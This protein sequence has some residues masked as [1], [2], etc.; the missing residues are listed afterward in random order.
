MRTL[1]ILTIFLIAYGSLFPFDFQ[2]TSLHI[3]IHDLILLESGRDFTG[4]GDLLANIALFIPYG[5][6]GFLLANRSHQKHHKIFAVIALGLLSSYTLQV[7]QLYLPSRYAAWNDIF[8][9][10]MGIIVG[11]L[12]ASLPWNKSL[13]INHT[14]FAAWRSPQGV[15]VIAWLASELIPFVPTLAVNLVWGNVKA[16]LINTEI[17]PLAILTKAI[18]W[19]TFAYL[20]ESLTGKNKADSAF[21]LILF[22]TLTAKF[23]IINS[24][25][26][27][28][29]LLGGI[30]ALT[31]WF[32]LFRILKYGKTEKLCLLLLASITANGILPFGLD[33]G[34]QVFN[35][36]P[37]HGFLTGDML[38]NS[39][40]LCEKLFLYGS[41]IWLLSI[42]S[43]KIFLATILAVFWVTLIEFAQI[44]LESHTPEITDPILI[45]I[46]AWIF[47]QMEKQHNAP[48]ITPIVKPTTTQ[49]DAISYKYQARPWKMFS[50]G[51]ITTTFM[52]ALAMQAVLALPK[53]PYNIKEL[54]LY[55]GNIIATFIFSLALIWVGLSSRLCAW[56]IE[57]SKIQILALPFYI[58]LAGIISLLILKLSVTPES[59][60][61]IAGSSNLN[62]QV[63]E[64]R[65]WGDIGVALFNS[66]Q[67]PQLI[68]GIERTVRYLA[69]YC[70]IIFFLVI[71]N[72]LLDHPPG[73]PH[74]RGRKWILLFMS[75]LPWL[76]L[77]KVIAFDYSSTDNLNELIARPGEYGIGGGGY[78]YL[79]LILITLNAVWLSRI[80]KVCKLMLP[81]LVT[82]AFIPIGWYLFSNGLVKDF[83]KYN[84]IYSGVDFLLGPSRSTL[85]PTGQLF[86]RWSLVQIA[87]VLL[88][89]FSQK[90]GAMIVPHHNQPCRPDSNTAH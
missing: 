42:P 57:K 38:H 25:I 90:L 87:L 6:I 61:D 3:T 72:I 75:A 39:Q 11:M 81:L 17:A 28:S 77:C 48:P 70:P 32:S 40:I 8:A 71:F 83:Q 26:T 20:L 41:L 54:F 44:F 88:L 84:Q 60:S 85:L 51:I 86:L 46:I 49:Q 23:F 67:A 9:N 78:L 36:L 16:L 33:S 64:K 55:N 50:I 59:I 29:D 10:F 4:L 68:S 76:F 58:F 45:V 56:L 18:S 27:T 5:F 7:L 34:A 12:A 1:F 15:L 37:F 13:Y 82:A 30:L 35:W 63:M 79:L 52:L 47:H 22:L 31:V 65:I 19:L 43:K 14:R 62:W 80:Q 74:D 73:Y 89:A 53:L 2:A 21:P 69:L 24:N 66:L